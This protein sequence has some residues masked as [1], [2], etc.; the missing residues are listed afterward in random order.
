MSYEIIYDKQFIKVS[1]DK[2]VPMILAGSNNCTEFTNGRERR[3]R[4]W[5]PYRIN[6]NIIV[7][8]EEMLEFADNKRNSI[9]TD[10]NGRERDSWWEEYRDEKFGYWLGLAIGGSCSST[11]FGQ[12]K[13]IFKTGCDK[14][15]TIE[16][17]NDSGVSV[18]VRNGYY[19]SEERDKLGIPSFYKMVYSSIQLEKAIDEFE[20]IFKGTNQIPYISFNGMGDNTPKYLRQKHF[21]KDTIVKEKKEIKVN[22]YFSIIAPNNAWFVKR[23]KYGYKYTHYPYLRFM[24]EKE[25]QRKLKVLGV[26]YKIERIEKEYTFYK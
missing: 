14:A 3:E 2:F 6:G 18:V 11:T 15:L 13:G 21:K 9:I 5:F 16:Q 12:F 19:S 22:H 25:A 10:N 4:S 1:K 24:T 17:L 8:K 23:T 20:E 26:G 7:T